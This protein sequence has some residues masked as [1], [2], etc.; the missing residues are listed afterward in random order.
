[1]VLWN[2]IYLLLLALTK[3]LLGNNLPSSI[4]SGGN[5]TSILDIYLTFYIYYRGLIYTKIS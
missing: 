2:K 3:C 1:M 4:I 5:S